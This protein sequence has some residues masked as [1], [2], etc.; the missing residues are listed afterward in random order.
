MPRHSGDS[1]KRKSDGVVSDYI[2]DLKQLRKDEKL[3]DEI[4][5]ARV[6]K[7]LGN[8]RIEIVYSHDEKVFVAQAK[9]PGRFTGRAKKSMMVS[10]GTFILVAKTGVVGPLSLEMAAIVSREELAKIQ[11]LIPVHANVTSV[12]T[13][14]SD[15]QTR[16]TAKE[17][18]FV[19]EGQ[20]EV[21][22]DNV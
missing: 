16:T 1:S 18:G 5:V 12:V 20:D 7:T 9:I 3:D 13:D 4:Y 6:I 19:F 11:E 22:I 8:A 10:P 21:D 14:T 15:L 17:D 2:Y